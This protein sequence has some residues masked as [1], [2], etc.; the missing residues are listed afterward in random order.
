MLKRHPVASSVVLLSGALALFFWTRPAP[1]TASAPAPAPVATYGRCPPSADGI[2]KTFMG[3]EISHVM[4]H[5]G[6]GWLERTEREKEE[7]PSKAIALLELRPD[8][9]LADIGA[10]S[11][12]YSFRI[13]RLLPEGKV[14]AVDIQPEMLA[15][16]K[17]EATKLGVKNVQPH[18]GAVDD[19][20]LPPASLDAA[21]M[22]DAYHEFD[23]PAEMLASLRAAL[24]PKGRIYL[25]EFR[26][27]DEN[28]PIK[29][30]HKMTEAQA[31]KEFEAGGFRFVTNKPDL[32]W[33]HLLIFEKP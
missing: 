29:P 13:A 12:Y 16:L 32:P 21:L 3:R 11:G 17:A 25:L 31:R 14:V 5:P 19:V 4:G 18:L 8:A 23:H 9:V 7:A 6:I 26:A 28:V 20:K 1:V 33:Q 30:H 2:G 27:E 15:F 24:R 22:V 10:G